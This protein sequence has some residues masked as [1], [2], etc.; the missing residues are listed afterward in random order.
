MITG[1][2]SQE[3][4]VFPTEWEEWH[5]AYWNEIASRYDR[6]YGGAWS[7]LEN[8]DLRRELTWLADVPRPRVL[9]LGCGTG[10]GYELCHDIN[11]DTEYVGVDISAGMLAALRE[12]YPGLNV[13]QESM[14]RL[15][16]Y[17]A[18]TFDLVLSLFGAVSYAHDPRSTVAEA[19]RVL[20][21]GGVVF[22]ALLNR[23]ALRRVL[24]G[25]LRSVT[26]ERTRGDA[27]ATSPYPA[28]TFT[29][30]SSK[31]LLAD[32]GFRDVCVTG[33]GLLSGTFERPALYRASRALSRRMPVLTHLLHAT[34]TKPVGHSHTSRGQT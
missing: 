7:A 4:P 33:F 5:L 32:A 8:D 13:V 17:T 9:D 11:S 29:Y 18:D 16:R 24:R 1:T 2:V 30:W 20:R 10:L 23:W 26:W 22:V 3:S 19:F 34:G 28:H 15:P 14:S 31:T 27:A 25:R 12:K 21:P 6:L